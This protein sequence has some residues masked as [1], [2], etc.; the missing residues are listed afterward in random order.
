MK[1]WSSTTRDL[2]E[3]LD[4]YTRDGGEGGGGE[5]GIE[6]RGRKTEE[7]DRDLEELVCGSLSFFS[8]F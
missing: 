4:A 7:L 5:G 1:K 6:V 2:D 3:E 8:V